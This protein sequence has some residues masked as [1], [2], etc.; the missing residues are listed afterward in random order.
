ML[1]LVSRGIFPVLNNLCIFS[2]LE[3][4]RS[5]INLLAQVLSTSN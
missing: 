3:F 4:Q 5:S 1:C 2:I